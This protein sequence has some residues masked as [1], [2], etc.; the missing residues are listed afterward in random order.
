[1][2][3][4]KKTLFECQHCGFSSPKWMAS[5]MSRQAKV[6]NLTFVVTKIDKMDHLHYG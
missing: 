4:K 5:D 3:K 1:M 6:S 2:A